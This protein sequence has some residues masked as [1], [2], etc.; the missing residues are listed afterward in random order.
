M[1]QRKGKFLF[2]QNRFFYSGQNLMFFFPFVF[3]FVEKQ[4]SK[5]RTGK[6]FHSAKF[7]SLDALHLSFSPWRKKY[8]HETS[9]LM[10][11]HFLRPRN[12]V[13]SCFLHPGVVYNEKKALESGVGM[14]LS[15]PQGCEHRPS[16]A[17][18]GGV[19]LDTTSIFLC[20]WL[21]WLLACWAGLWLLFSG[22]SV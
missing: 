8:N 7:C 10:C 5:T 12:D 22:N 11:R 4:K 14:G 20:D 2:T 9:S 6:A 18:L 21:T 17:P 15:T 16:T 1:G 19:R 13:N 3:F